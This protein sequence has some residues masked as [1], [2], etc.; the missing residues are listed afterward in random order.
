MQ[1]DLDE[2]RS[3][4]SYLLVR[5]LRNL[6]IQGGDNGRQAVLAV[7]TDELKQILLHLGDLFEIFLG[8]AMR[9]EA[10]RFMGETWP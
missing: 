7:T 10:E 4:T 3:Y 2:H 5:T 6:A 8:D 1:Q 9:V